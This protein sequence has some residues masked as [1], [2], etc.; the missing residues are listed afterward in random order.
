[1]ILVTSGAGWPGWPRPA[2]VGLTGGAGPAARLGLA[3]ASSPALSA[4]PSPAAA[5]QAEARRCCR[6]LEPTSE[7]KHEYSPGYKLQF[8]H[9]TW[10]YIDIRFNTIEKLRAGLISD[11]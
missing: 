6:L 5:G 7:T 11:F 9:G 3:M 2:H 8:G 10:L 1:M 4:A